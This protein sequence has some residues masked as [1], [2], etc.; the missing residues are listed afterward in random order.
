MLH[1]TLQKK[2]LGIIGVTFIAAISLLGFISQDIVLRGFLAQENQEVTEGVNRAQRALEDN[3]S[4]LEG[5]SRDW[6][7]WDDTYAYVQDHN[8]AYYDTNLA[9]DTPM[10]S[11][12]LNLMMYV[13]SQARIVFDKA[14]DYNTGKRIAVPSSLAKHVYPGSPLLKHSDMSSGIKGIL[15][16]P[17][18]PM[19][20][21]SQPILQAGGKGPVQGSLIFGRFLDK[22]VLE[23]LSQLTIL[24][25]TV[26]PID[27]PKMVEDFKVA[28][29]GLTKESPIVVQPLDAQTVSGYTLLYDTDGKPAVIL[30]VETNRD[31]YQQGQD[32]VRYYMIALTIVGI[33]CLL[34]ITLI[35][36]R[37]VLARLARL[38]GAVSKIAIS[39]DPSARIT[40]SGKDELSSV[41]DSINGMLSALQNSREEQKEGEE[42][43]S[44]AFNAT[45]AIEA[46]TTLKDWRIIDV[47]DAFVQILGYSREEVL[48]Q[49]ALELHIFD[50]LD[51]DMADTEPPLKQEPVRNVEVEARRK[52]G[53]QLTL[54]YSADSLEVGGEVYRL[55]AA[56]DITERKRA[57]EGRFFKV[58]TSN[59]A[60]Q[61][62]TSLG[63]RR[64]VAVNEAFIRQLGYSEEEAIGRTPEEIKLWP[65]GE[66]RG[67]ISR[68]LSE[69]GHVKNVEV[70]CQTKSGEELTLLYSA[71]F[72]HIAGDPCL[73]ST[74][75]DISDRKAS[76]LRNLRQLGRL[77]ALRNIDTAITSSLDLRLT[78]N[79]L[80][81]QVTVQLNVDAASLRLLNSHT[82]T[83]EYVTG[84]GFR[85]SAVNI[86]QIRLGQGHAG[87]AALEHRTIRADYGSIDADKTDGSSAETMLTG[88]LFAT[89]YATPLITKGQVKGVLEVYHRSPLNPDSEWLDYLETLAGQAA[90]AI[91]NASMFT[92]LQRSNTELALAYD[93][94]LEGWSRALDLRDNET[95]GHTQRV[96][97]SAVQ[98]ARFMGFDEASLVHVR[99]G[100]LLH[101]IGKMGIP[102]NIL[103][104]PGPLTDDEWV[105]MR[106]HPQ[107]AYD[108]LSP[109]AFLRTALDI[110]HYHHEKWDGSGYPAG[111]KGEHIPLAARI[112]AIA[113]VW[114]ALRSDRPY[115][116]AWSEEKVREHIL[117]LS[118][119]HFDPQ[120]VEAFMSVEMSASALVSRPLNAYLL[121]AF[122]R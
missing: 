93:T 9:E 7:I 25:V 90:I 4:A 2:T 22:D 19:L 13:D 88:E 108:L 46:I 20:I 64:I 77:A 27:D 92:D 109:I 23:H 113:D 116:A 65:E 100:A 18:G 79:V 24:G 55:S 81:D 83:L 33:L 16:L 38:K 42:R 14:I 71:E 45:P 80:I 47:N 51:A 26:Q 69:H 72:L 8:Q 86:K 54:L 35:L 52:L 41:A 29:A 39:S 37:L 107:Y 78:L 59:P 85:T 103:L 70:T 104:K 3:L 87:L 68:L 50:G 89:Y 118:G 57:E 5:T 66:Q 49:S 1:L 32:A 61:I 84:R 117:S 111:L 10:V 105:I 63:D 122:D 43:F 30:R 74:A 11:L 44:K 112:F 96:T 98:L 76:E 94:T 99:R 48:G 95:E 58:F 82:R 36:D 121:G 114:D 106:R 12:K 75:L 101:D 102:D 53:E 119:T 56:I 21:T 62:L 6:A 73:L 15:S 31:I 17:E 110:P 40:M 120:V 28:V 115:R 97:Q 67:S 34:L 60:I 91:D